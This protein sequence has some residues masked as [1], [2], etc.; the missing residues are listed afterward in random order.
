MWEFV[1]KVVYINL[2][3][4]T[5]RD[6]HVRRV[7]SQFGDK[8]V[9]MSAVDTNPGFIGCLKSHIAVLSAAKHYGWKNVLVVE[10]DVEW[11]NFDEGYAIVEALASQPYDLIHFGPSASEI[12]PGTYRLIDGQTTSSY[13]ISAHYIDTLLTCYKEALPLLEQTLNECIYGSDQ[14]WKRLMKRDKW[15]APNPALMYQRPDHSDIRNRFQD[16]RE[17]WTLTLS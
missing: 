7:L 11:N 2:D 14:C 12:E 5:D 4:R 8:V 17:F 10:D 16:H 13:L 3:R 6:E 1:D 15:F 9:R